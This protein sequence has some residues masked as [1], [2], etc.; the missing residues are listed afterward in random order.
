[1][2]AGLSADEREQCLVLGHLQQLAIAG[3]KTTRREVEPREHDLPE[4][5]FR[6][7]V[8]PKLRRFMRR[9]ADTIARSGPR[10]QHLHLPKESQSVLALHSS[11]SVRRYIG[12]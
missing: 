7:V 10:S 11:S 6:H 1:M 4:K 2:A 12:E 3:G 9:S 5:D 8:V